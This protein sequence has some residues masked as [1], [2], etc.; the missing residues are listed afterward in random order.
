MHQKCAEFA[1]QICPF[2]S[3]RKSDYS[4]R[5]INP[6]MVKV[7]EMVS[8]QRP[9]QMFILAAWTKKIELVQNGQNIL[10]R[11]GGNWIGQRLI[12]IR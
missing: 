12:T 2:V 4:D 6:E 7:T 11:V 3:G 1:S 5:P 9:E 8:T 10:I